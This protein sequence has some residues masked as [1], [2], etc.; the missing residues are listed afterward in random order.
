MLPLENTIQTD[1]DEPDEFPGDSVD[2]I[3][4]HYQYMKSDTNLCN[5]CVKTLMFIHCLRGHVR[6]PLI[7][8]Y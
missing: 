3:V 1:Q 6:N 4:A 2:D 8:S 7:D 5:N